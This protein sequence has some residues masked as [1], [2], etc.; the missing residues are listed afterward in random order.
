MGILQPWT[1]VAAWMAVAMLALISM[2]WP[3]LAE[4]GFCTLL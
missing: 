4:A 2:A 1:A 3:I